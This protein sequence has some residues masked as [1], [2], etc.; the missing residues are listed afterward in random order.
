MARGVWGTGSDDV[1]GAPYDQWFITGDYAFIDQDGYIF[2]QGRSDDVVIT[3]AGKFGISEIE[4]AVRSHPAVAD[5][6]VIRAA[7][8]DGPKRIKAFIVLM[9]KI[10]SGPDTEQA[11]IE[12]IADRISPDITPD[13]IQ[14]CASLPRHEDGSINTM[15]LKAR[16]L[17]LRA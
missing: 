16:S 7:S 15:E 6:A 3:R 14:W 5:A 13:A 1:P 4:R 17:G 11:I 9:P 8:R 12:H 2:Y 10:A